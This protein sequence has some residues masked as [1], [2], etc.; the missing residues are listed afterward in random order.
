MTDTIS[1]PINDFFNTEIA[2]IDGEA[3]L[4]ISASNERNSDCGGHDG[5]QVHECHLLHIKAGEREISRK[6]L[7]AVFGEKLGSAF[8]DQ[9][10]ESRERE[11]EWAA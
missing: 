6:T 11:A 5:Y 8:E 1:T 4:A 7:V 9:V 2:M 10:A 3:Y